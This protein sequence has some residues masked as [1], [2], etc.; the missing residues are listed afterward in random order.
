MQQLVST[1][2]KKL[3]STFYVS[4]FRAQQPTQWDQLVEYHLVKGSTVKASLGVTSVQTVDYLTDLVYYLLGTKLGSPLVSEASF[5]ASVL[6][7]FNSFHATIMISSPV[8]CWS[9]AGKPTPEALKH[10]AAS[11][12]GLWSLRPDHPAF[13]LSKEILNGFVCRRRQS[14]CSLQTISSP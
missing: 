11:Q 9:P 14:E 5:R 3:Y 4:Q 8:A 10:T 13:Q 1:G 7:G 6:K 2:N 12:L